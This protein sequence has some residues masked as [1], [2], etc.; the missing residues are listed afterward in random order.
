MNIDILETDDV[1]HEDLLALR[2]KNSFYY[3][4]RK[5]GKQITIPEMY[6]IYLKTRKNKRR[7][8][9][10]VE[11]EIELEKLLTKLIENINK[12]IYDPNGN[13]TFI[14]TEPTRNG[15]REVFAAE[16]GTRIQH[17]YID[18]YMRD[19]MEQELTPF[20]FNNRKGKGVLKAVETVKEIIYKES[21]GY[22]EDC[23]IIKWDL[24]AFFMCILH[25]IIDK[26]IQKLID[27]KY[28][29]PEKDIL[30][31]MIHECIFAVPQ[32][33]CYKKSPD[34]KWDTIEPHK[35]LFNQPDGQGAAIGFLVWQ[36]FI[37]YYHNDIDKWITEELGL[38]FVRFVDDMLIITKRKEFVL[39]YVLPE[40]RIRYKELNIVMQE[41][42]FYCQHYSKGVKFCGV[43]IKYDRLYPNSRVIHNMNSKVDIFNK[44]YYNKERHVSDF[45]NMLNS[46]FGVMKYM[47]AM[48]IIL[49]TIDRIDKTWWKYMQWN[50]DRLIIEPK[51]HLDYLHQLDAAYD[52]NLFNDLPWKKS[53]RR[54]TH[55][56]YYPYIKPKY[57]KIKKNH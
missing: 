20:T 52:L 55:K 36:M 5:A 8:E 46:Y 42:K 45:T 19:L 3:H 21:N 39:S 1:Q 35:S 29:G 13:Y 14:A 6:T 11:F 23:W 34:W 50:T 49:Q 12:R 57:K 24:K 54:H 37:N 18:Y 15:C 22:T 47:N 33:H 41:K 38:S 43:T 25:D 7:S 44:I 28:H 4:R 17:H 56:K 10:S 51:P 31:W 26:K 2:K 53:K 48:N 16:L 40:L 27:D 30:K 9:D 32:N